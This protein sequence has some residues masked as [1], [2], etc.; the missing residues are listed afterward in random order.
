M[1]YTLLLLLAI[2]TFA[3]VRYSYVYTTGDTVIPTVWEKSKGILREQRG[4]V[5]R[6]FY[7][8]TENTLDS[9]RT[10]DERSSTNYLMYRHSD[11]LEI[12]G[13]FKGGSIAISK[14]IDDLP[15]FQTSH[16]LTPFS[17]D[18]SRALSE[19]WVVRPS[20]NRIFKM[21]ATRIKEK[22]EDAVHRIHTSP[23]GIFYH[24]WKAQLQFRKND[25]LWVEYRAVHGSWS[26]P[27]TIVYFVN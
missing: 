2:S 12:K 13:L 19:Y 9:C 23:I 25:G 26:N 8:S 11:T 4:T 27:E 6:F 16:D 10:I 24:L 7:Y 15:W 22:G 3:Q 20:D 18:T 14:Q 17:I 21:R 5:V 1:W